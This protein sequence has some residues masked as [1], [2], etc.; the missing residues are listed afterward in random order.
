MGGPA[1]SATFGAQDTAAN[2]SMHD[3]FYPATNT[4]VLSPEV[5]KARK[6]KELRRQI[7]AMLEGKDIYAPSF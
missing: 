2:T 6:E 4:S 7:D 5:K 1:A 3:T